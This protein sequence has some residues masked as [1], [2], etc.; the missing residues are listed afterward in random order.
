MGSP[1]ILGVLEGG[2]GIIIDHKGN[3]FR[4]GWSRAQGSADEVEMRSLMKDL[5]VIEMLGARR[6]EFEEDAKVAFDWMTLRVRRLE[7]SSFCGVLKFSLLFSSLV[8]YP[9]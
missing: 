4:T 6:V 3:I 5:R 9:V 1:G 7:I 2:G 8:F